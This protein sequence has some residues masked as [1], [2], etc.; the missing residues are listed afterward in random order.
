[1]GWIGLLHDD[2]RDVPFD[3]S[4]F[5]LVEAGCPLGNL[6]VE[7][8][9]ESDEG[10]VKCIN[11]SGA[12]VRLVVSVQRVWYPSLAKIAVAK[13]VFSSTGLKSREYN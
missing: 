12:R 7:Q 4:L 10:C 11:Y 9:I 1:M 5:H 13:K 8:I 2:G 3:Y 6:P